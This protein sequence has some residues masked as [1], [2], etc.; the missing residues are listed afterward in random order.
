MLQQQI[1]LHF[2]KPIK[3]IMVQETLSLKK[4]TKIAKDILLERNIKPVNVTT[5]LSSDE[6]DTW[7]SRV[8]YLNC[9]HKMTL[10]L[11]IKFAEKCSELPYEVVDGIVIL[12]ATAG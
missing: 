1:N 9:H 4:L 8:F 6:A 10:E 11:N 7:I 5:E 3:S 2:H 12:Y